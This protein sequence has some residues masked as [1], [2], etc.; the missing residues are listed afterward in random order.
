MA[1]FLPL[2]EPERYIFSYCFIADGV[3]QPFQTYVGQE[4]DG[5]WD[6]EAYSGLVRWNAFEWRD[7]QIGLERVIQLLQPV[8]RFVP[9]IIVLSL[10]GISGPIVEAGLHLKLNVAAVGIAS[11]RG[12]DRYQEYVADRVRREKLGTF[13]LKKVLPEVQGYFGVCGRTS[14]VWTIGRSN[15]ADFALWLACSAP[16]VISGVVALSPLN[17]SE[18]LTDTVNTGHV[19]RPRVYMSWGNL[20]ASAKQ[21]GLAFEK[22]RALGYAVSGGPRHGGHTDLL[23]RREVVPGFRWLAS[24]GAS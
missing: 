6:W 17:A 2:L 13:V 15:G 11:L 4:S 18:I 7:E 14:T 8:G 9:D 3:R 24:L 1:A 21:M 22:M 10:D 20:E 19:S 12:R 23:W 16:E 5:A